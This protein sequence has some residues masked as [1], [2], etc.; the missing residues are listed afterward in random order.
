M[1]VAAVVNVQEG[2]VAH[3]RIALG[4]AGARPVRAKAAE[5]A[6]SGKPLDRP[7]VES[8]AEAALQDAQPFDDSYA[9]AWY[10]RRVLPVHIRRALLGE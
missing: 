10:R 1:T 8:A 6:L 3:A 9:S 7:S 2:S 5:A 4:G